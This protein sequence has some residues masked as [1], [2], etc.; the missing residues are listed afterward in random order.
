MTSRKLTNFIAIAT[1]VTIAGATQA[2]AQQTNADPS[3]P[4]QFIS[5]A[6]FNQM[7]LNGQLMPVTPLI[8]LGQGLQRLLADLENQAVID[9]FI[10][11]NPNLSGFA[12]MVYDTPVAPN[13]Y[14]TLGGSY[15]TVITL[16]NGATQTIKTNGQSV[17]LAALANAIVTSSDPVHE[18]SVYQMGYSQYATL[19]S[20]LCTPPPIDSTDL[21]I[22][23]GEGP[24]ANLT[25]PS[26]LTDPATL[27]NAP[28]PTIKSALAS[29]AALGQPI[30]QNTPPPPATIPMACGGI[31]ESSTPGVNV[32][33]GDRTNN[34][35]GPPSPEAAFS[36]IGLMANFN[37]VGKNNLS[38]VKNQG[39]RNT[40]H[41]FA[42]TSVVEELLKRDNGFYY[43]LSE[44]DFMENLKLLWIPDFVDDGGHVSQD[45]YFASTR[46]YQFVYENQW[47][48]N[49]SWFEPSFQSG[50][51]EYT[52][53]CL[54]YPSSEPG[55]SN[56]PA[57]APFYCTNS[58]ATTGQQCAYQVVSYSQPSSGIS[59]PNRPSAQA[60]IW[61]AA[62]PQISL[63]LLQAFLAEDDAI[64]ICFN[65][66]ENFAKPSPGGY[67]VYSAADLKTSL[68]G[69][70]VHLVGYVDNQDLLSSWNSGLV[71]PPGVGGGYFI[72][73]NSYGTAWGDAGYGYMPVS[74]LLA[75]AHSVYVINTLND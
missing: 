16:N 5:N 66:T 50:K 35:F 71:V 18:L 58:G 8:I 37:F 22:V 3:Q 73:K 24:C 51:Y 68:G 69:H 72:V 25:A 39:N 67:I 29:L 12:Q 30:A 45:F 74:Y 33:F 40:C 20:Q 54:Y 63:G 31:G 46:G 44:E 17:K 13:V 36:P 23:I 75:T 19:Y 61:D 32:N 59:L 60:E 11:Q 42:A 52:A 57:Q 70:C 43:D 21:T 27:L 62:N 47:D 4:V 6:Q 15:S 65:E 55:C 9:K 56:S 53:S 41:I 2:L 7:V 34:P 49:P 1:L 48:Y 14:K 26:A 10:L 28:L 38:C 64:A